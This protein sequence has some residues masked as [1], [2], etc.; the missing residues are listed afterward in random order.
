[1]ALLFV[2][3]IAGTIAFA[4]SG[5]LTAIRK[6]IDLLGVCLMGLLSACGGGVIRDCLLGKVPPAMFQNP[7]Y[8]ITAVASSIV[9][10]FSATTR[11]RI[12]GKQNLDRMML[13]SDAAGLGTFT[14]IGVNTVI[15][16]GYGDS[17]FFAVSLG[18]LSGVGGGILRDMLAGEMPYVFVKHIYACASIAGAIA[19]YFIWKHLGISTALIAS[20][21]LTVI[22]RLLAAHFRWNLPR[23]FNR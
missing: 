11:F 9:V 22:I 10:F 7:I 23:A 8:A 17:C 20:F 16:A 21:S 18:V 4:I 15:D 1:M 19:Y 5:A 14:A 2:L 6:N 12:F 3:E 13:I